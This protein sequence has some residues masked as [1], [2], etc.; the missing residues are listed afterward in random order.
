MKIKSLVADYKKF[1]RLIPTIET[2]IA[3]PERVFGKDI[4]TIRSEFEADKNIVL[5]G[6]TGRTPEIDTV[7]S[8]RPGRKYTRKVEDPAGY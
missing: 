5:D 2:E 7:I 3:R 1:N 4:K 8:D 6:H